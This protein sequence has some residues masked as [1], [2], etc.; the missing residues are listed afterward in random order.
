MAKGVKEESSP[1][2]SFQKATD[3]IRKDPD[4]PNLE[5]LDT[6]WQRIKAMDFC[7]GIDALAKASATVAALILIMGFVIVQVSLSKLGFATVGEFRMRYLAAGCLWAVLTLVPAITG[8]LFGL[9][10]K[11]REGLI[12]QIARRPVAMTLAALLFGTLIVEILF[13]QEGIISTR[14]IDTFYVYGYLLL[15]LLAGIWFGHYISNQLA[16]DDGIDKRHAVT[17]LIYFAIIV[18]PL[19]TL[20]YSS[21]IYG[22]IPAGLG[23]GLG[24]PALVSLSDNTARPFAKAVYITLNKDDHLNLSGNDAILCLIIEQNSSCYLVKTISSLQSID[25]FKAGNSL[26]VSMAIVELPKNKVLGITYL[27]WN[28]DNVW[29]PRL[30]DILATQEKERQEKDKSSKVI[31]ALING[32]NAVGS[33]PAMEKKQK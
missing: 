25:N 12:R 15:I 31:P 33:V 3:A 20:I 8:V 11:F 32:K 26:D 14:P 28:A 2:K 5:E 1:N 4:I 10:L 18:L 16:S 19:T 9:F 24:T 23:G 17:V 29:L 7:K 6:F 30:K 13:P 27:P 21:A 22:V